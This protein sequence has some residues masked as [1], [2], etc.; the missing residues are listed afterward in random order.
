MKLY[1]I[2]RFSVFSWENIVLMLLTEAV[3]STP[4]PTPKALLLRLGSFF[5]STFAYCK[6]EECGN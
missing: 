2:E 6:L 4:D 1:E 5:S 3:V